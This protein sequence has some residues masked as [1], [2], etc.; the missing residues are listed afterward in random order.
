MIIPPPRDLPVL[1]RRGPRYFGQFTTNHVPLS[2]TFTRILAPC[3]NRFFPRPKIFFPVGSALGQSRRCH[4]VHGGRFAWRGFG[5]CLAR[6]RRRGDRRAALLL[7]IL[8]SLVL[9]LLHG[10]VPGLRGLLVHLRAARMADVVDSRINLPSCSPPISA[11]RCRFALNN[12]R[13]P[14]FD[15]F[16]QALTGDG[17][18]L[19]KRILYGLIFIF[20]QIA[21]VATGVFVVTRFFRQPLRLPLAHG[22]EQF[23]HGPLAPGPQH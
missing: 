3:L 14:F 17:T 11:C 22:D 2:G 9:C 8:V 16:Q 6:T 4:L 1:V 15:Q 20:V 19:G 12:W 21:F 10:V 13:R 7:L 18:V 5:L 23:L